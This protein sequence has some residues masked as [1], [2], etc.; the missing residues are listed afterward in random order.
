MQKINIDLYSSSF[1]FA[2]AGA[3][4]TK[5]LVDRFISLMFYGANPSC[6]LCI[7][8]TSAAILEIKERIETLLIQLIND[9]NFAQEYSINVLQIKFSQKVHEK[10]Q[11][12]LIDWQNSS[13]NIVTVH[14]FCQKLL[15]LYPL[16]AGIRPDFSIIENF[17]QDDFLQQAKQMFYINLAAKSLYSLRQLTQ[18]VS[19]NSF[20]S[21][22]HKVFNLQKI[23]RFFNFHSNNYEEYL[24]KKL[25]L[26]KKIKIDTKYNK[27][28]KDLFFT[29]NGTFRKNIKIHG[30]T[31]DEIEFLSHALAHNKIV[32]NKYKI[33]KKTCAF[34][35][36]A[37]QIFQNYQTLKS[38]HNVLDFTDIIYK[39]EYLLKN[40]ET[41]LAQTAYTIS[42]IMIDEAQDMNADQWRIIKHISEEVLRNNPYSTIFAVGDTKQSIYSFQDANPKLFI[43]FIE[44][45]T[46]LLKQCCK[47]SNIFHLNISYRCLPKI[48]QIIDQTLHAKLPNYKNHQ[49]YRVGEG[50]VTLITTSDITKFIIE[51]LMRND[52]APADIMILTRSRTNEIEKIYNE[53]M[54]NNIPVIGSDILELNQSQIVSD[55]ISVAEF[56]FDNTN[57]YALACILKS[58]NIMEN[59]LSEEE[60][61]DLCNNRTTNLY[62]KINIEKLNNIQI[63]Q[64]L[65]E[66]FIEII[67]KVMLIK[68]NSA[69]D[70]LMNIVL[71]C[72]KK[73]M[74]LSEFLQWFVEHNIIV[75]IAQS[76]QNCIKIS[77]IH[78]SKGLESKIVILLDF[79]LEIN[80][81][82]ISFLWQESIDEMLFCLKPKISEQFHEISEIQDNMVRSEEE[83]LLR[84]LYVAMTR[85]KNELYI[86][87]P[88]AENSAFSIVYNA[89]NNK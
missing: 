75:N 26:E 35:S 20:D 73:N 5:V 60:I 57:D 68:E 7:T 21:L 24:S 44:F 59:P 65:F 78:G 53:L 76:R 29:K 47:K 83:E 10:F 2:S 39:A 17:E 84:L 45:C 8:F 71:K 38:Q 49:A 36:L 37:H 63:N 54:E 85:A 16:E 82:K 70:E 55:V 51:L 1:V 12:M 61:F 79:L 48:L 9:E 32:D 3:G 56:V 30:L 74:D 25:K 31:S 77:T 69:I 80:K 33:I 4:K 67:D 58:P 22:L 50:V 42:H 40:N 18:N 6:I 34:L 72:D 52:V 89:I 87:G 43:E 64:R 15:T 41:I 66:I 86:I 13:P 27:L 14:S 23:R 88:C 46:N 62:Q 28:S 81:N 19:P 11:Q